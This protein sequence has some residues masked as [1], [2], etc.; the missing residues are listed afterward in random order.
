MI[1]LRL[2]IIRFGLWVARLGGWLPC[3]LSHLPEDELLTTSVAITQQ[4]EEKLQDAPSDVKRREALRMLLNVYP[5]RKTRDLNFL[6]ELAL[7][8]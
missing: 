3:Q 6:I 7:Q 4:V 2:L 8:R 1:A 5:S